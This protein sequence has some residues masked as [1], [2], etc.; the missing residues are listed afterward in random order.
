MAQSTPPAARLV[1]GVLALLRCRGARALAHPQLTR[2]HVAGHPVR[3]I[4]ALAHVAPHG[5]VGVYEVFPVYGLGDNPYC[6]KVWP[7]ALA[8]SARLVNRSAEAAP[9][10]ALAGRSVLELGAG[11]GLCSLAAAAAG[12]RACL[13]TDVEPLALALVRAAAADQALDQVVRAARFDLA[14]AAPL[15]A[16]DVVVLS[17]LTYDDALAP[18]CARRV[19]EARARGSEVLVAGNPLRPARAAFLDALREREEAREAAAG[20]RPRRRTSPLAF[21]EPRARP[22]LAFEPPF[23]VPMP[24]GV[25]EMNWKARIVELMHL[26]PRGPPHES[27]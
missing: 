7:A 14:S 5:P 21:A 26:R 19:L 20:R 1:I 11:S 13:A 9:R 2:A 23:T 6:A 18:H 22:E 4:A 15:P 24:E 8:A 10:A 3:P 17:D 25:D 12:A 27:P 16:A